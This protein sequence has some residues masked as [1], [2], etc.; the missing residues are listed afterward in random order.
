MQKTGSVATRPRSAVH[1]VD[2]RLESRV[3]SGKALLAGVRTEQPQNAAASDVR[4]Q[5]EQD[6]QGRVQDA[7]EQQLQGSLPSAQQKQLR[8]GNQ[9]LQSDAEQLFASK[10]LRSPAQPASLSQHLEMQQLQ[11]LHAHSPNQQQLLRQLSPQEG[12]MQQPRTSWP[13]FERPMKLPT[14]LQQPQQPGKQQQGIEQQGTGQQGIPGQQ[15]FRQQATGQQGFGQRPAV[16]NG[17]PNLS[18]SMPGMPIDSDVPSRSVSAELHVI[19]RQLL[20]QQQQKTGAESI[21]QVVYHLFRLTAV[22]SRQVSFPYPEHVPRLSKQMPSST[23]A[24]LCW[25]SRVP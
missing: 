9:A 25:Y 20:S 14:Q 15:S 4:Q 13:K 6:I 7:V 12:H 11:A 22:C 1:Q 5:P 8:P 19:Q 24:G 18:G 23:A 21:M 2:S 10:S 17:S 16:A 3:D